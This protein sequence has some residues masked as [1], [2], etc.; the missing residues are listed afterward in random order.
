MIKINKLFLLLSKGNE[1]IEKEYDIK[2]NNDFET[3]AVSSIFSIYLLLHKKY[4]DT[5]KGFYFYNPFINNT[6]N[7]LSKFIQNDTG[8]RKIILK[9]ILEICNNIKNEESFSYKF[10]INDFIMLMSNYQIN[11]L[12]SDFYIPLFSIFDQSPIKEKE[13]ISMSPSIAKISPIDNGNIYI[14]LNTIN[15]LFE[16]DN[17]N[18]AK[19]SKL[20]VKYI[21]SFKLN[22]NNKTLINDILSFF[23]QF[24]LYYLPDAKNK[25]GITKFTIFDIFYKLFSENNNF[26]PYLIDIK[27]INDFNDFFTKNSITYENINLNMNKYPMNIRKYLEYLFNKMMSSTEHKLIQND[28]SSNSNKINT[29]SV[30]SLL[31]GIISSE[32]AIALEAEGSDEGGNE[33]AGDEGG[34]ED[35]DEDT[36]DE[37]TEDEGDDAGDENEDT[38]DENENDEDENKDNEDENKKPPRPSLIKMEIKL[39]SK[40]ETLE[41]IIFKKKSYNNLK[42]FLHNEKINSTDK[43]LLKILLSQWFFLLDVK[44]VKK[45]VKTFNDLYL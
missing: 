44:F 28:V 11:D 26:D 39:A 5:E 7:K 33:D 40:D 30:E 8:P 35:G 14:Y 34:D 6:L 16:K 10:S 13:I 45:I 27:N 41:D 21:N 1:K 37:D 2:N 9:Q 18:K 23:M 15:G 29:I 36:G 3:I 31:D 17:S 20:L 32:D 19:T 24:R 42:A 22:L 4:L 38:N 12:L 43:A 25:I